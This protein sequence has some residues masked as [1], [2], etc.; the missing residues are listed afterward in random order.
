MPHAFPL[1]SAAIA[2]QADRNDLFKLI[3]ESSSPNTLSMDFS[4]HFLP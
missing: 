4:G 3:A 1:L 2:P